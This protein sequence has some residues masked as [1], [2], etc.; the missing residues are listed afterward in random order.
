MGSP[1]TVSTLTLDGTKQALTLGVGTHLLQTRDGSAF[2]V[3]GE[4]GDSDYFTI[5]AGTGW[6]FKSMNAVVNDLFVQGTV[7]VTLEIMILSEV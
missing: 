5:F 2:Q 7:G 4:A 1:I 6:E 3:S